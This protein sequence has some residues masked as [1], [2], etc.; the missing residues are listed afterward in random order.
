MTAPSNLPDHYRGAN[1]AARAPSAPAAALADPAKDRLD[2]RFLFT[3]FRRRLKLFGA[4]VAAFVALAL[5][6]T[7]TQPKL[8]KA[9]ADVV[10]NEDRGEIVPDAASKPDSALR[11]EEIDT[12]IKIIKS[13]RT[14]EA[15]VDA[16]RL[17]EDPALRQ[18][19][20]GGGG[21]IRRLLGGTPPAP[22]A[23]EDLR[24]RL[25]DGVLRDLTVERM[26]TAYAL[27][28]SFTGPD[29]KRAAAIANAFA[30]AYSE[31][32]VNDKRLENDKA[33]ALLRGRIEDLRE[34]AQADFKAAQ[35]FRVRNDLLSSQATQL[36]EQDA[37]AYG[38]QLAAARASAAADQGKAGAAEAAGAA[39]AVN[40]PVI[41]SL[42]SQRAAISI[43]VADMAGRYL[44]THPDLIGARRELAD[45]DA[46]IEAEIGRVR[47]GVNAGRASDAQATSAQVGSL[48]GNLASAQARLAASNEALVGLDDLS[49]KAQASQS[50]Y[51]SYLGRYKE[52]LAQAG[53][54]KPAARLLSSAKV[55]VNPISPSL[56]L[57]L[58]LGLVIGTLLGAGAAIG[59]E[60]AFAGLTTGDDVESRLGVRYLGGVP[61]LSSI[62]VTATDPAASIATEP[63]SAYAEAIRGLLTAIRG[64]GARRCQVV[65][66]TSALPGEGKTTIAASI[67]RIAARGGETAIVLDCDLMRHTLSDLFRADKSRPG[68][69]EVMRAGVKLG[70]AM[71]KDRESEAMV[72]PVTTAFEDGERLLERGNFHRMIAMMREHFDLIVLDTA[73][74]LPV[75]ETRE[76]VALADGVVVSCLW[77]DT[78]DSALRSALRL[79]PASMAADL[80]IALNRIDMKK[81]ARFGGDDAVYYYDRYKTLYGSKRHAGA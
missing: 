37:A 56:V 76:I 72:L 17:P 47:T 44:D 4:I 25:A 69:R 45:I 81:Q 67:A 78:P 75:A 38:Q 80:G 57:N 13:R 9:T 19:M 18:A 68:M 33:L 73:P 5:A 77:R 41:Q 53:T 74:I 23:G 40:S 26:E 65:A 71:V 15:V 10:M 11:S 28:I 1:L 32:A 35:D 79:L 70:D 58:A 51:E 42:R 7:M 27:R 63:D 31:S 62:D 24:R 36:A 14:A 29:P 66:V 12:Q 61:L 34:Q 20:L 21:A 30:Q 22:P 6:F 16:L 43:K 55:P 8:Y 49:R 39:A 52:I 54:E 46:Q 60:A 59:A 50:L 48:R 3:I 64:G 2:L